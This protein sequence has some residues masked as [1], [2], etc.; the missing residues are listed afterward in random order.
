MNS[1][2]SIVTI[3]MVSSLDGF[4]AKKDG[5]LSW[6]E[7]QDTYEKGV[8]LSDQEIHDFLA[9]IDCYVIGSNTYEQALALGWPYGETAVF[10][11]SNR[12]LKSERKNVKFLQG[13]LIQI[14]NN[15]LKSNYK[16]IWI[17]GG[18]IVTKD[19][20]RLGLADEITV[21]ILPVILGDGIL[22]F[23]FVGKEI[24]LHLKDVKAF[25]EG[26]VELCY[27]IKKY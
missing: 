23:D 15:E 12:N 6:M 20:L 5:S 7:T 4:I 18:R 13:D 2:K 14:I 25:R 16:N 27:E 21:T 10:V 8:I 22:F 24:K 3:H 17:A 9:S 11:L 1:K 19:L 26:M